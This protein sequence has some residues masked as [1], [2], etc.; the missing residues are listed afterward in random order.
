M[1]ELLNV[2]SEEWLNEIESIREH[3]KRF[4]EKLPEVLT[5]QLDALESRLRETN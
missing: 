4:E 3:Y 5:D 2:N 1:Q